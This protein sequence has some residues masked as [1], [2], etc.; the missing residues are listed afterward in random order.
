ML[1]SITSVTHGSSPFLKKNVVEINYG[2]MGGKA[3][4]LFG[5]SKNHHAVMKIQEH[6]KS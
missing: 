5:I 3:L 6:H 4:F 1:M 2:G